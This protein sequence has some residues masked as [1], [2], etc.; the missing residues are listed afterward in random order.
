MNMDRMYANLQEKMGSQLGYRGDLF[1]A[2]TRKINSNT[3]KILL[4]YNETLGHPA[5]TDISRFVVK[6]FDGRISPKIETA[7]IYPENG[8]ISVVIAK[9]RPIRPM[10]DAKK[11]VCIAATIYLDENIGDKWVV[12]K[13]GK[14][15]FLARVDEE[16]I[17]NIVSQRMQSMQ[18]KASTVTFDNVKGAKCVA[19][20][21][22]GDTVKY[23]KDNKVYEGTIIS[24]GPDKA[25][26]KAA[27]GNVVVDVAAI[28]EIIKIG[29]GAKKEAVDT[30][31]D[32]YRNAY[33]EDY[34]N[35][36]IDLFQKEENK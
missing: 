28:F 12:E 25:T 6:S 24:I 3:A 29:S 8:A 1:L 7:R 34:G 11:M 18:I 15:A 2:D 36:Y 35:M 33:P 14:K 27:G 26:I 10:E 17:A 23:F 21:Q 20:A 22:N 9:V 16:D 31:R 30:L 13:N 19:S 32:Y 5:L 4:G